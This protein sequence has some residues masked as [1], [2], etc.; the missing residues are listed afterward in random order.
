MKIASWNVNSIKAR[1]SIALDWIDATQPD[2]LCL[3]ETKTVDDDFPRGG[4]EERG[5]QV[6][7][8]GQKSYNGVAILSKRP[9]SDV[10]IGFVDD[11]EGQQRRLLDARI[12]GVRVINVYVPNGESPDS[13]KFA[14][15]LDWLS[16][17]RTY[18]DSTAHPGEPLVICGDFNIAPE[19]RDVYDPKAVQGQVLFHP[20]EHE[21]LK[22]LVDFGLRDSFRLFQPDPGHYSWWDYRM[23]AF[24]RKMGLRIDQLWVTEPAANRCI[25][26]W[27]DP[28]PR[29]LEKPSDHAPIGLEM[30]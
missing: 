17:L 29:K 21:A 26:G 4:F 19:E 25:A 7:V 12:D 28:A 11:T 15:K 18:L 5:Y 27:I 22:R 6:A 16:R 10:G 9:L 23:M 24:R 2:V 1:L 3:Q 14:Y 8:S 20:L 30:N 13:P